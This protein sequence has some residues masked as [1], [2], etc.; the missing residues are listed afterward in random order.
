MP[1]GCNAKI[2]L[3]HGGT[4]QSIEHYRTVAFWYG[5]P[6][7]SVTKTDELQIGDTNAEAAHQYRSPDA[8]VPYEITSR[9]ELGVDILNGKETFPAETDWGR[10]TTGSSEFRLRLAP[11]NF[12]VLLRRKLDYQFPNQ[13]AE[14]FIADAG[15]K[16][17]AG[18]R[19]ASGIWPAATRV[20]IPIPRRNLGQPNITWRPPT[21]GFGTMNFSFHAA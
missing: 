17:R 7:A 11:D 14:V 3:E 12:G 8:S 10:K 19:L 6:A 5:L 15:N 9:Y 16:P 21:A 1:F 20:F 18:S 13:R 4:D 2:C